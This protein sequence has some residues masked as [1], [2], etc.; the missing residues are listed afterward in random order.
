LHTVATVDLDV[1][2]IILP[3]DAELD[4]TLGDRDDLERG[5]VLGVLLEEG[6]VL[7]SKGKL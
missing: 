2:G 5:A 4:H 1:A 7:K 6:A 3:D